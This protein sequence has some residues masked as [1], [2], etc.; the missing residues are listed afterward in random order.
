L[1]ASFAIVGTAPRSG[2]SSSTSAREARSTPTSSLRTGGLTR[3]QYEHKV[4]NH[5]VAYVEGN[6]HTNGI[7]NFWAFL[8]RGIRGTYVSVEPFHPFRSLDE[9]SFRFNER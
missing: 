5:T 3:P 2:R 8:K 4:I 1:R 7:E 6:V 9:H